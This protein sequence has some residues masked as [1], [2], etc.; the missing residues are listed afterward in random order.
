MI[1]NANWNTILIA[2]GQPLN[3]SLKAGIGNAFPDYSVFQAF[4]WFEIGRKITEIKPGFVLLDADLNGVDINKLIQTVKKDPV[5]GKPYVFLLAEGQ[6]IESYSSCQA[7]MVLTK[8][9]DMG[10]I[11]SAIKNLEKPL[12]IASI[13]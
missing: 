12:D 3:D 5:F 9:P 10:K 1:E 4:D 7:D 13:A 11:E 2:V 6:N 8:P